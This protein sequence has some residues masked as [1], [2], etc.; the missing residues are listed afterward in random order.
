MK[1]LGSGVPIADLQPGGK[2][3]RATQARYVRKV[4]FQVRFPAD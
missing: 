2:L 3:V 4:M 1:R